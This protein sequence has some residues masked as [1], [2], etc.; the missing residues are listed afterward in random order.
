MA[1]TSS[2]ALSLNEIH[3]EAGGDTGT[4]AGLND[5]DIRELIDKNSG[6]TMAF[7]EWYGATAF[8]PRAVF[9]GGGNTSAVNTIEYI[10]IPTTGNTTDFGDLTTTKKASGVYSSATRAISHAGQKEAAPYYQNIIDYVTIASTGNA[11][12]FGDARDL[13][14]YGSGFSNNTRG[15]YVGGVINNGTSTANMEYVTIASTGNASNFGSLSGVNNNLGDASCSSTTRGI[16]FG[17]YNT[18]GSNQLN[19]IE[20][21]TIGTAGNSVDFGDM[22][23]SNYGIQACSSGTRGVRAGG[24]SGYV[25]TMEYVTIA[26]TGNVTDFGNL[27]LG[28]SSAAGTSSFVRGVFAGG[29]NSN[30]AADGKRDVIDYITIASAGNATDF[31]NLS[32]TRFNLAG[33]SN[34]HGG[35]PA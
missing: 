4:T 23:D 9:M 30:N 6:A 12:D 1:L 16:I 33:T 7:N 2:G 19:V 11:T 26:S 18:G 5:T 8:T 24:I 14:A 20:Y 13:K 34:S 28:R 10:E 25:N 29:T 27:S 31:G 17:G 3:V 22:S 32:T 21:V 35:L 15:L